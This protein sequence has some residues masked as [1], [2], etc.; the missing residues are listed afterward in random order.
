MTIL[1]VNLQIVAR[2]FHQEMENVEIIQVCYKSNQI[3]TIWV[4]DSDYIMKK[5]FFSKHYFEKCYFENFKNVILKMLFQKCYSKNFIFQKCYFQ[6]KYHFQ[7]NHCFQ[8][9]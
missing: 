5:C 8:K 6:K 2:L 7:K 4:L 9:C 3:E 1:I